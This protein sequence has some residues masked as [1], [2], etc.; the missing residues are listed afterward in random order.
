MASRGLFHP[1]NAPEL[2]PTGLCSSRRSETRLRALPPLPLCTMLGRRTRLRRFAPSENRFLER[3][4]TPG[5]D[6]CPPD[7]SSL[8]LSLSLPWD[9]VLPGPSS[10]A[11]GCPRGRSPESKPA[12]QSLALQ[13]TWLLSRRRSAGG[14]PAPL[15]FAASSRRTARMPDCLSQSALHLVPYRGATDTPTHHKSKPAVL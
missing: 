13:R 7:V 2:P 10:L 8:R 1:G 12:P 9:R 4:R 11:L 3:M 14:V 6:P 15:R 5:R